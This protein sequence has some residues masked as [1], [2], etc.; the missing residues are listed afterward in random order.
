MAA[1]NKDNLSVINHLGLS[2]NQIKNLPLTGE[3]KG[4][5]LYLKKP[6]TSRE[7]RCLFSYE[8]FTEDFKPITVAREVKVFSVKYGYA[9][10]LDWVGY[11]WDTKAKKYRQW[12]IDYKI[13]LNPDAAHFAQITA[14]NQA[15][16]ETFGKK[17]RFNLGILYLGKPTKKGYFFKEV[18]DKKKPFNLFLNAMKFWKEENSMIPKIKAVQEEFS[19]KENYTR[20]GKR[21]TLV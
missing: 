15:I 18:P 19:V 12:I 1:P 6:L 17:F 20:K 14:Y 9:G 2:E 21:L 7:A 5:S 10:T 4:L 11:L 3:D 8:N 13:S 16:S